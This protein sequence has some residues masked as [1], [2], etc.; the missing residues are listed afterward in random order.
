MPK[1]IRVSDPVYNDL[2]LLRH[3]MQSF[4]DVV[5]ELI[6]LRKTVGKGKK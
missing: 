3:G 6:E 1:Q 5:R 4:D 2:V